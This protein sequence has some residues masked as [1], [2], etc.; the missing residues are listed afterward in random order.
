MTVTTTVKVNAETGL[1]W[2]YMTGTIAE[3]I[4]EIA[5]QKFT[6]RHLRYYSDNA[7]TAKALACRRE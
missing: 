7:T 1:A 6:A 5:D 4:Q 3:V 2:V